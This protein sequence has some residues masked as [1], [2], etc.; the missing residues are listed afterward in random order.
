MHEDLITKMG[1][2]KSWG[3]AGGNCLGNF[4][5]RSIRIDKLEV[6]VNLKIRYFCL[7]VS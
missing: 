7:D 2:E 5:F 1:G 6:E 3:M 4:C